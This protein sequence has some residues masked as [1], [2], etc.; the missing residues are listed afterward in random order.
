MK[1]LS[2]HIKQIKQI[3][4]RKHVNNSV[5]LLTHHI[6][7]KLEELVN[8]PAKVQTFNDE[9]RLYELFLEYDEEYDIEIYFNDIKGFDWYETQLLTFSIMNDPEYSCD[10]IVR[11]ER[12]TKTEFG[13]MDRGEPILS[14]NASNFKT[15]KI[16]N[17][18]RSVI[19]NTLMHELTHYLQY[20]GGILRGGT[21]QHDN[22][23]FDEIFYNELTN[24]E[25][26]KYSMMAFVIYSFSK[27]ERHARVTGFYG[28]LVDE[29][30]KLYDEYYKKNKKYPSKQ[31]FIDYI[32]NDIRY[33][34]NV[35]HLQ[36]Y[37][38][39]I[40]SIENDK[41]EYYKKCIESDSIYEDHS[42]IYVFLNFCDHCDPKPTFLL[43]NKGTC[44]Y[45]TRTEDEYNKVKNSIITMFK[46]NFNKYVHNIKDIISIFYDEITNEQ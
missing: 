32:L 38:D 1:I 45:N 33:N 23:E 43:P 37:G 3:N 13:Y 2:K 7:N 36:H 46:K 42:T 11:L 10:M 24:I 18:K 39:F 41:Y 28:T 16:F 4:E 30:K 19:R 40:K 27:N 17:Q 9:T 8:K 25:S 20:M 5:L 35:L 44:V 21:H 26:E 29:A 22:I 31:E 14:I 6:F 34:D 15:A 12:M